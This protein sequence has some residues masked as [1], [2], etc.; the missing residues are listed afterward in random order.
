VFRPPQ[1]LQVLTVT[2]LDAAKRPDSSVLAYPDHHH[3]ATKGG[4]QP[5]SNYLCLALRINDLKGSRRFSCAGRFNSTLSRTTLAHTLNR[6]SSCWVEREQGTSQLRSSRSN[7][8]GVH[9]VCP[10][11]ASCSTSLDDKK[12]LTRC[13]VRACWSS[14]AHLGAECGGLR[15]FTTRDTNRCHTV[16]RACALVY[17]WWS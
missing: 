3:L 17:K 11:E 15:G 7:P 1:I 10:L 2:N 12:A 13:C 14:N 8:L 5:R 4:P 9:G 16:A 6:P